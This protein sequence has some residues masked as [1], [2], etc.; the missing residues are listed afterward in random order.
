MLSSGYYD[1]YYLKAQKARTV[2]KKDF[3]RILDKYDLIM[4]PTTPSTAF[5]FGENI[6]NPLEMYLSDIATIP[7][8][9]TGYPSLSIPCG[10]DENNLPF[11]LQIMGKA[12]DEKAIASWSSVPAAY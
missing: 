2:I 5:K 1:A 10:F 12:F 3:D 6:D 9:M 8:N 7:A 11:G 4:L